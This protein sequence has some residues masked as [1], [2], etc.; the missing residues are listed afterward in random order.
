MMLKM[1]SVQYSYNFE[2]CCMQ[3]VTTFLRA[4]GFLLSF[5]SIFYFIKALSYKHAHATDIHIIQY[6]QIFLLLHV[7]RLQHI[8]FLER[9]AKATRS[10]LFADVNRQ[11]V[12]RLYHEV[13]TSLFAV[14]SFSCYHLSGLSFSRLLQCFQLSSHGQGCKFTETV[15]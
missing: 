7:C 13:L 9:G 3:H 12:V 5:K 10:C 14:T 2:C 11:L 4:Y 15:K 6:K 1:R 8:D